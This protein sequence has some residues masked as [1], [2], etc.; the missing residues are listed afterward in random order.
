MND[1][2][3]PPTKQKAVALGYD[4]KDQAPQVLATGQGLV[5]Q[6]IIE[7]ARE[8][9]I[10]LHQD[11]DLTELLS[12]LELGQDIPEVLYQAVAEILAFVYHLNG[13]VPDTPT[14]P[15]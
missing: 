6:Q 13:R 8:H 15:N 12:V 10:P 5:A 7:I 14:D 9:D 2:K 11:P 3:K 1:K 4:P